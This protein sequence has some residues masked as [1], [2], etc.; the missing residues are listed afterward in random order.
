MMGFDIAGAV[1]LFIKFAPYV[2]GMKVCTAAVD[3]VVTFIKHRITK[4]G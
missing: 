4:G 3:V 2:L 1:A